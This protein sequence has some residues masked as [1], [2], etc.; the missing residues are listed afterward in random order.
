MQ[1]FVTLAG[2]DDRR[3]RA[4]QAEVQACLA[5]N[6]AMLRALASLS[7][8]VGAAAD[9]AL[10]EEAERADRADRA[11][12]IIDEMRERLQSAPAETRLARAL[13]RALV[14]AADAL[15]PGDGLAEDLRHTG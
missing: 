7:P 2:S 12:E 8:M 10:E 14:E 9:A 5:L 1:Q 4:M 11:I 3:L 15:S 13:E 6:R